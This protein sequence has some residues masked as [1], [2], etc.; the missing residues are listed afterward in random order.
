TRNVDDFKRVPELTLC[1]P[2]YE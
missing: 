2:F 1:N